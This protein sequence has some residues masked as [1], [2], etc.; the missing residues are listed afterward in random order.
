MK[1][2][3]ARI[4]LGAAAAAGG[5]GARPFSLRI[6]PAGLYYTAKTTFRSGALLYFGEPIEVGAVAAG[7]DGEPPRAAV[8]ELSDRIADSLRALTLNAD[9]H[10]ALAVVARAERIFS[11][12][13]DD[14]E[15]EASLAR[16]L[17]RRRRFVEGYAFHR[18][19][20]PER[21]AELERRIHQYE[22]ELAQA[23][24][25]DPRQLSTEWVARHARP[26]HLLTRGLVFALVSPLAL[27]GWLVHYPAYTL[28]GVLATR[29]SQNYDDV[30]STFK[31][32]AAMLLFPL[33]WSALAV[34]AYF[35]FGWPGALAALLVSPLAGY[36]ALRTREEFDRFVGGTRAFLFF[37]TSR[38]FFRQLLDERRAIRREILALG[39]EAERAA[40]A[41]A[42]R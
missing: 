40:A 38:R 41:E 20:S 35:P 39:D 24:I 27:A 42:A 15:E 14:D 5:E 2:G 6:V 12:V 22:E 7:A 29:L 19:R 13:E 18:E 23:G 31:I 30:L 8:R 3:A 26:F 37:V 25:E 10:E 16:E 4:A 21:L 28:A 33:T 9:R 17:R 11:S 1:T 34:A 36:T 32:M